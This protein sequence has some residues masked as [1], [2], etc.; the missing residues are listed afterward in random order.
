MAGLKDP[1]TC[2]T[3]SSDRIERSSCKVEAPD[4]QYLRIPVDV[5]R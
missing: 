1:E 5:G 2:R 3:L 4:G